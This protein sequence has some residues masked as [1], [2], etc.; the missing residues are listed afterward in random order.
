LSERLGSIDLIGETLAGNKRNLRELQKSMWK[1]VRKMTVSGQQH[2]VFSHCLFQQGAAGQF[3][4][5]EAVIWKERAA[6]LVR[7]R[8]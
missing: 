7:G 5:G 3:L 2:P 6:R 8:P 4:A 1:V